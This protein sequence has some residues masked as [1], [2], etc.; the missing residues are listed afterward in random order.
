[1]SDHDVEDGDAGPFAIDFNVAHV[2]R[3]ENVV[4]GGWAHFSVDRAAVESV[5]ELAAGGLETLQVQVEALKAFVARAVTLL[6][7]E[8]GIRQYLDIGMLTPA[9]GMVHDVAGALAAGTR[10]VYTSHDA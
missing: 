8:L 3:F 6:T 2:A 10:V 4:S 1:M 9:S 7:A 5:C